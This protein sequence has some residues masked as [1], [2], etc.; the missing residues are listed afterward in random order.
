MRRAQ[1]AEELLEWYLVAM[2]RQRLCVEWKSNFVRSALHIPQ[3]GYMG[4]VRIRI[5]IKPE[6]IHR[7]P[8][9]I[10]IM[11]IHVAIGQYAMFIQCQARSVR[12]FIGIEQDVRAIV[13]V[14]TAL[15]ASERL[16]W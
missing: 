4:F 14:V 8:F 5:S 7:Q 11:P 10:L 6:Q 2:G 13:F 1:V 15:S 3:K 12:V 16:P 9:V